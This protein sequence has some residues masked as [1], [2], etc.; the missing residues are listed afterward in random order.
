VFVPGGQ[1]RCGGG[2]AG[3]VLFSGSHESTM[4]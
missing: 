1:V 4:M 3:G 2:S